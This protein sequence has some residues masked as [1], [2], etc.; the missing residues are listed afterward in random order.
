MVECL[1]GLMHDLN[2]IW[3]W[4]GGFVGNMCVR[5]VL[6]SSFVGIAIFY[7]LL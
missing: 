4:K 6:F 7:D 2:Q 3:G 1:S 5:A